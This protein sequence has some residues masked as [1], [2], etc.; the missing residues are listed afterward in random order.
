[1]TTS[2]SRPETNLE[3]CIQW[4]WICIILICDKT[5]ERN[6]QISF[7]LINF[8][9][10]STIVC[11][12]IDFKEANSVFDNLAASPR[13]PIHSLLL[14]SLLCS[15]HTKYC[16]LPLIFKIY[17]LNKQY[18]WLFDCFVEHFCKVLHQ[19]LHNYICFIIF[20]GQAFL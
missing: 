18:S 4:V 7:K 1:M 9:N 10:N 19:T 2:V 11:S 16:V 12:T 6:T 20:D 8:Y 3:T 15:S 17:Y 13:R 14:Q 5:Y